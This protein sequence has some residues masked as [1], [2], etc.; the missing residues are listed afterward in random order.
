M[1]SMLERDSHELG[2]AFWRCD[3]ESDIDV[4]L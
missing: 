2:M 1:P 4:G 3:D